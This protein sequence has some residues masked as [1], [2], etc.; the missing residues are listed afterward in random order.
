[1]STESTNAGR[2]E[3]EH[4]QYL[5]STGLRKLEK[6]RYKEAEDL[7]AD[8]LKVLQTVDKALSLLGD[9]GTLVPVLVRPP[10]PR[11]ST[12]CGLNRYRRGAVHSRKLLSQSSPK[13]RPP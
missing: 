5:R 8:A 6:G 13:P 2:A 4:L 3:L 10:C 1:M 9:L 11:A 12:S 7:L